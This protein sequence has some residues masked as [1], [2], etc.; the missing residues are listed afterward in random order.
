MAKVCPFIEV[1]DLIVGENT[2][3]GKKKAFESYSKIVKDL[4][5]MDLP[6]M[7]SNSGRALLESEYNRFAQ[8]LEELT[9]VKITAEGIA[10]G[11][12][13]VN[14]KRKSLAR[15]A[16][17]RDANPA[18]ISGLD[19][20]L[21]N[22]IS[23]LDDPERFTKAVNELCEELEVRVKGGVGVCAAKTPRIIISGCPMAIPNW[24]LP[25]I[26]ETSNLVIIGEEM[27]TGERGSRNLT[28]EGA[29]TKEALISAVTERYFMIDCAVFTPNSSRVEHVKDMVKRYNA[30]GVIHYSLQCCQPYTHESISFE[31]EL[32]NCSIPTLCLETDYSQ[33]DMGQLKTRI[34][35]F[36]ERLAK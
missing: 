23:F 33:E 36:G 26:V 31:K 5:V 8:R 32:E 17:L 19:V 21:I 27:C 24:K 3:D 29:K 16:A 20:L 11:I 34:E 9:G 25:S 22:Q 10:K 13:I 18:P 35:A 2:C 1:S 7:K 28:E 14:E 4:Y 12:K 30:D 15:L 6:Q